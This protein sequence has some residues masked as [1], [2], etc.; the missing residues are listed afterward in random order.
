MA[1]SSDSPARLA[2]AWVRGFASA[3]PGHVG[4]RTTA[5]STSSAGT[6]APRTR[7]SPR[8]G[9]RFGL[10]TGGALARRAGGHRGRGGRRRPRLRR[11]DRARH[12]AGERRRPA[13]VHRQA[14]DARSPT[15]RYRHRAGGIARR[16]RHRPRGRSAGPASL[17]H[18]SGPGRTPGREPRRGD[19]PRSISPPRNSTEPGPACTS[20]RPSS[21]CRALPSSSRRATSAPTALMA[22]AADGRRSSGPRRSGRRRGGR[23]A[24]RRSCSRKATPTAPHCC[25]GSR[26]SSVGHR[27]G[28]PGRGGRVRRRPVGDGCGRS[29]R[30]DPARPRTAPRRGA[31][32]SGGAGRAREHERG[33]ER[34]SHPPRGLAV[35]T[36]PS[37]RPVRSARACLTR[38]RRRRGPRVA[39]Q[40]RRR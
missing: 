27:P 15:R 28:Q 25:W 6:C 37:A 22:T 10:G 36:P 11:S 38:A 24:V 30:G 16:D 4:P 8:T 21:R 2:D 1:R 5:S 35:T 32:R 26:S 17:S 29:R 40:L 14:G 31:R 13:A 20:G 34:A 39:A 19:G 23:T 12:R 33:G 3:D 7:S 9:D 18:H